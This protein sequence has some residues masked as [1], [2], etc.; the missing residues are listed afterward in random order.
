MDSMNC[1]RCNAEMTTRVVGS[2]EV[3]RCPEGHGVFLSRPE[4]GALIEAETDWHERSVHDTA[5]L[6]RITGDMPPPMP[7][8]RARSWVETLFD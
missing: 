4:L 8:K 1:P 3:S 6:P 5:Q 7:A 2:G